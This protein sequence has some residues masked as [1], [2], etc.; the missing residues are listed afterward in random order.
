[1]IKFVNVDKS[2]NG[3]LIIKDINFTFDTGLYCLCGVSGSGKTTIL[4]LIYGI[5]Q[6]DNGKIDISPNQIISYVAVEG[7]N[8]ESLTAFDNLKLVCKDKKKILS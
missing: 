5:E 4:N 2:F 1:M 8:I 6:P 3:N 7:D